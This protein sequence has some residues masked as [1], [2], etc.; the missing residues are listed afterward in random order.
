MVEIRPQAGGEKYG[1]IVTN[2]YG[3]DGYE[4]PL[5]G[6]VYDWGFAWGKSAQEAQEKAK[7]KAVNLLK[8]VKLVVV[9]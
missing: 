4:I 1:A 9:K 3:Y 5:P 2:I 8:R 6:N 7:N